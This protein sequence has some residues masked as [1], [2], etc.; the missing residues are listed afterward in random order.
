[1]LGVGDKEYD[2]DRPTC[3]D[4][5]C[6]FNA[7]TVLQVDVGQQQVRPCLDRRFQAGEAIG[8]PNDV[9]AEPTQAGLEFTGNECSS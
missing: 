1:M 8:D 6:E 9:V 7:V 3:V 4:L 5:A 2:R